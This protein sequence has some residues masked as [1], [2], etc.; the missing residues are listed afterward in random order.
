MVLSSN[1]AL[2][3]SSFTIALSRAMALKLLKRVRKSSLRLRKAQ[4]DLR[5]RRLRRCS[6]SP[7]CL[8]QSHGFASGHG[9]GK[10]T[11]RKGDHVRVAFSLLINPEILSK[12][13]LDALD[14]IPPHEP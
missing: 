11:K 10:L 1:Q 8:Q 9:S 7:A 6:V 4:R 5:L 12:T 14:L 13:H 3:T 2:R